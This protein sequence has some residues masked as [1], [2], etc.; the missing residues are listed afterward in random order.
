MSASGPS[1]ERAPATRRSVSSI[2]AV[3]A[4]APHRAGQFEGLEAPVAQVVEVVAGGVA[5]GAVAG[6]AA[7]ELVH[8]HA[9]D[10]APEVPQ[11]QVHGADG[12]RGESG[13]AEGAVGA[14]GHHVPQ[15]LGGQGRLAGQHG[16]EEVVDDGH[17]GAGLAGHAH[18]EGA[19]G[20][21]RHA[22]HLAPWW[23]EALG[24]PC[25]GPVVGQGVHQAP[26]IPGGLARLWAP[27][28]P[29]DGAA[30]RLRSQRWSA[31]SPAA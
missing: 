19:I 14:A 31:S 23:C 26:G 2:P 4:A 20:G 6:R 5:A 25:E 12:I 30:A 18:P 24:L 1:S 3:A 21:G 8:G 13:C 7:E 11:G 10:L 9:Q 16:S 28:W 15:F 27:Q 22:H 29:Q 17:N